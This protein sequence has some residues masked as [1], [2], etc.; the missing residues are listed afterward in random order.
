VLALAGEVEQREAAWRRA[1]AD[2]A[3][4]AAAT[5]ADGVLAERRGASGTPL[6]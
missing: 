3:G 5:G 4:V 1:I 6:P 2:G